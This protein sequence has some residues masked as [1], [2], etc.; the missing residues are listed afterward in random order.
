LQL[1][2]TGKAERVKRGKESQ[3]LLP[4]R[5]KEKEEEIGLKEV[6]ADNRTNR[7]KLEFLTF[8]CFWGQWVL[9][10]Q[11]KFYTLQPKQY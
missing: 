4:V 5:Q 10:L 2:A 11:F 6:V 1:P 7:K 9:G 3:W 8:F